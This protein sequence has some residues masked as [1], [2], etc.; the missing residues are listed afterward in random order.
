MYTKCGP[1]MQIRC[2]STNWVCGDFYFVF[3]LTILNRFIKNKTFAI[4]GGYFPI[5]TIDWAIGRLAKKYQNMPKLQFLLQIYYKLKLPYFALN[6]INPIWLSKCA[7]NMSYRA[8]CK[9]K[10]IKWIH[11]LV[12]ILDLCK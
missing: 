12:V 5:L 6:Y 2:Y 8:G 10:Y 11:N 1:K 3:L 7:E 4:C 9:I